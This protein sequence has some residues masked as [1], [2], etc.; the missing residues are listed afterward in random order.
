MKNEEKFINEIVDIISNGCN[1]AIDKE[2]YV[3]VA[4]NNIACCD[5]LLYDNVIC[6]P[7][8]LREWADKEYKQVVI[9]YN[10]KL[11][12]NFIKDNYEYIARDKNGNLFVYV[13]IPIKYKKSDIWLGDMGV[14]I[15]KFS[16]D[17]PMIK[18]SDAQA[19]K[20]SD[21]KKLKVVENY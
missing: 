1:L 18:W 4:C 17:F 11:F 9:S 7:N 16:I 13:G 8:R 12:L 21:L 5:C 10:D 3:P 2:T 6:H 14:G 19:W 15:H 20:I